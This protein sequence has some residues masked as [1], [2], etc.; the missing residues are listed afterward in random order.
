MGQFQLVEIMI[1]MSWN[2][3]NV[4]SFSYYLCVNV[5]VCVWMS[6]YGSGCT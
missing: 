3:V 5:C 1:G 6:L 4:R 2:K